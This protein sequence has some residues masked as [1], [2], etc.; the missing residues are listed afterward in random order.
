MSQP[1]SIQK[2]KSVPVTVAS[3]PNEG[4]NPLSQ[5]IEETTEAIHERCPSQTYFQSVAIEP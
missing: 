4:T 5:S 3:R 1:K 2:S